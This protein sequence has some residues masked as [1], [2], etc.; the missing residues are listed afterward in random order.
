MS[1]ACIDESQAS[2]RI[3]RWLVR[4]RTRGP[5]VVSV[6]IVATTLSGIEAAAVAEGA[7]TRS[8]VPSAQENSDQGSSSA[9]ALPGSTTWY[10]SK[11]GDDNNPGTSS[12]PFL[13][14]QK[15]ADVAVAGDTV[16]VRGGTYREWVVPTSSGQP[17][18]PITFKAS[19]G[20]IVKIKGS[21]RVEKWIQ[22][23]GGVWKALVANA[24][25]NGYNPFE[26]NYQGNFLTFGLSHHL[27]QVYLNDKRYLE[28]G[29]LVQ[30]ETT[31]ESWFADVGKSFTTIWANFGG[32]NPNTS[33]AE[34][35]VRKQVFGPYHYPSASGRDP[36]SYI[37]VEGFVLAQAAP[38][39]GATPL[40]SAQPPSEAL[41]NTYWSQG[42][43]IRNNIIRDSSAICVGATVHWDQVGSG[44]DGYAW[45]QTAPFPGWGWL[46]LGVHTVEDNEIRDCQQGGII[47]NNSWVG[48]VFQR[49]LIHRINEY[50]LLGGANILGIK[51]AGTIDATISHNIV[52]DVRA[53]A[54]D[55]NANQGLWID[56]A[57]QG[58]RVSGNIV[59]DIEDTSSTSGQPL[60][61][62]R[63]H[64]PILVDNNVFVANQPTRRYFEQRSE[65]TVFAHNLTFGKQEV[66]PSN[67][68]FPRFWQ[69]HS[70]LSGCTKCPQIDPRDDKYYNNIFVAGNAID[71]TLTGYEEDYNVFYLGVVQGIGANSVNHFWLDPQLTI[72]EPA[73][74][75]VTVSFRANSAPLTLNGPVVDPSL[76]G[77]NFYNGQ[78]IED[79]NGNGITVDTD[80]LGNPRDA[81]PTA[82]PLENLSVKEPNEITLTV[83]PNWL[84]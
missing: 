20:D 68:G 34:I 65:H 58:T 42:W 37:T 35:N 31:P 82:G 71:T 40:V 38:Q 64:G 75:T 49:N 7:R 19:Q 11:T 78:S 12:Q 84:E 57:N 8:R 36:I 47:G 13:T 39:W 24:V 51:I 21:E 15:G 63:N 62:E 43:V 27:G 55:L 6:A 29:T 72:T 25:F 26:I 30:V 33:L 69:P 18:A 45:F 22:Q 81:T 60:F 14:I 4:A 83:G 9:P 23:G 74:R 73:P 48:S 77:T 10:V 2:L 16:I 17:L 28:V 5:L 1:R 46:N 80:I 56:F 53:P 61:L 59:Y 50:G 32:A 70:S 76:A 66:P 52:R 79:R 41:I 54:N 44:Y 3:P 67:T